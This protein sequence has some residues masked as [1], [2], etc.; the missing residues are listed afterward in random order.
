MVRYADHQGREINR[1]GD[2]IE[3]SDAGA[4]YSRNISALK[5]SRDYATLPPVDANQYPPEVA[6]IDLG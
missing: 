4:G 3:R 6:A 5:N 2:I 1:C